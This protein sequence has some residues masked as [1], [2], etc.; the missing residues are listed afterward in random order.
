[1]HIIQLNVEYCIRAMNLYSRDLSLEFLC[2]RVG[3]MV[4]FCSDEVVTA[5]KK[6]LFCQVKI[7]TLQKGPTNTTCVT[8]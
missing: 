7:A 5:A 8:Q 4:N 1:M 6:C 2:F 3:F